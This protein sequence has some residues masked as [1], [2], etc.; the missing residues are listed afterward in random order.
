MH[1]SITQLNAMTKSIIITYNETDESFLMTLFKRF[2]IK[3]KPATPAPLSDDDREPTKAEI[4]NDLKEAIAEVNAYN[5]G[6]ITLPT[7]EELFAELEGE[8]VKA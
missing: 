2:K 1:T 6:E 5:R 7:I 3:T 4:L 8:N